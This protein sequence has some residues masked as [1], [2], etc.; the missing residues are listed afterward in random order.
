MIEIKQQQQYTVT[1]MKYAFDGLI[2]RLDIAEVYMSSR[3]TSKIW[4]PKKKWLKKR[5]DI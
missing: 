1:V 3:E 5:A 2:S 4:M